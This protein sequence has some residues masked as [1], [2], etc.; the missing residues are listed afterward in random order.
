MTFAAGDRVR[1]RMAAPAGHTRV[2]RYVRGR[3][4]VVERVQGRWP[5][6]DQRAHGLEP[7]DTPPV[8][9]VRFASRDLFGQDGADGVAISVDLWEPY[10]ERDLS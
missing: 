10:L 9:T 7:A 6:P 3:P 8:Y 5:L 1:V 2:P 4:G